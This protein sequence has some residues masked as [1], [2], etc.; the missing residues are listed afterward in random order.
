MCKDLKLKLKSLVIFRSLL[1]Q[2]VFAR[3]LELLD[4][5]HESGAIA[6][7]WGAFAAALYAEGGDLGEFVLRVV[8]EDEN[9][10]T[11]L[12]VLGE[13]DETLLNAQLAQELNVLSDVAK[14]DGSELRA[15]SGLDFLAHWKNAPV[16]LP[17]EYARRIREAG[18]VGFGMFAK[19]HMF[20]L[21]DEG[22]LV[23]IRH[24]DPQRLSELYGYEREREGIIANTRAFLSGRPA[25]N[26]LLYG[27]AGTGKSSTVKAI[28]NEFYPEGLRLVEL[29]KTQLYM[30]QSLM[31][32]LSA[33]PLKFI[34]FIDDLTFSSDDRDFCALK[35]ILEGGVSGRGSNI[36]IYATSNHRHLV[37][38]TMED[39]QG[40]EIS[41][42]DKRQ[43]LISL[44]ARFGL[45]VTFLRPDK[46][47][48][49]E[50]V[51]SLA[52]AQGIALDRETLLC[53]AEAHAIRN[54]GRNP[55]TAKQFIDLLCSGVE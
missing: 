6:E 18:K 4:A 8:A 13:G 51:C 20:I 35:A 17:D 45:T 43:E 29:K 50:I 39:R 21:N 25:N 54:G 46:D 5:P 15:Q 26:V 37:K 19:Y 28:A 52:S 38:E 48:Y 7:R 16:D 31:D 10:Y 36:L 9:I 27:D 44:S 47:L 2:P 3:L 30:I 12:V 49:S 42:A 33:N 41:S 40:N 11:R 32:E 24:P 22:H 53:R 23:P 1:A 55:R 14:F 34:F